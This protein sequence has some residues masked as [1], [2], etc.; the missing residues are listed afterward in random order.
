M[1]D[2]YNKKEITLQSNVIK[3][4]EINKRPNLQDLDKYKYFY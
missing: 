3:L 2:Y 4:L 1:S